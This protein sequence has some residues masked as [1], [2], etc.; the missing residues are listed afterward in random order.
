MAD[1]K[2]TKSFISSSKPCQISPEIAELQANIIRQDR[3]WD[4]IDT[5][6]ATLQREDKV[7]HPQKSHTLSR[8]LTELEELK[9][10][11]G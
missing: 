2:S 10:L 4:L 11:Y 3:L 1:Q 7:N 9:G 6:F 8:L 5:D